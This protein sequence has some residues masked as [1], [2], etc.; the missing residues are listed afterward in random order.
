M[1]NIIDKVIRVLEREVVP[2]GIRVFNFPEK[3]E[4]AVAFYDVFTGAI[5][6][7]ITNQE[8]AT[9]SIHYTKL[10]KLTEITKDYLPF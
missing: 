9:N 6:F 10:N 5:F 2:F 3:E 7:E 4:T 8:R 1:N